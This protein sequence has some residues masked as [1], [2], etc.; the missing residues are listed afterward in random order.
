M[1]KYQLT[2]TD[3][4]Y[5]TTDHAYLSNR[6]DSPDYIEYLAWVAEGNTPD[7]YPVLFSSIPQVISDRQFFHMLA[8]TGMITK[9]E[10]LAAVKTG[11]I[12]SSMTA[13][14]NSVPDPEARFDAEMLLSGAIEFRRDH[15][16]TVMIGMSQGKTP[17]EI[18]DFFRVAAQL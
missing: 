3:V 17:E 16:L 18:D 13:I 14:L 9:E 1:A 4:I 11:T 15:P 6:S 10:A 8:K 2:E 12:P 5:R 7:P